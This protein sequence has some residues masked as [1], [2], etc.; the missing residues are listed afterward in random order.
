MALPS[1]M[2]HLVSLVAVFVL[3]PAA[4]DFEILQLLRRPGGYLENTWQFPGGKVDAG[5]TAPQAAVRELRE[6]TGLA[7]N[8]L[9]F[10]T[11]VST[12]YVPMLDAVL[13][14]ANFCC[15]IDAGV[16]ITLN[17]EHTDFRW[18]GRSRF[19]RDVMWPTDRAALAEIW[20]EHLPGRSPYAGQRTL[21][22][23]RL[24]QIVRRKRADSE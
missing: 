6:E 2:D 8:R 1:T 18:I 7:P 22:V 23:G 24:D 10:L 14:A 16:S 19:R 17:E 5:E 11:H 3:K 9:Q 15:F 21:D 4:G 13:H 20:R 12:F